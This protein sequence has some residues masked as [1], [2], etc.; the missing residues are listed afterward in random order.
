MRKTER[1]IVAMCRVEGFDL[2]HIQHTRRHLQLHFSAGFVTTPCTPSDHRNLLN[3][4]AIVRRLHA[5]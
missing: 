2:R 1:E 4:R 5:A 3:L